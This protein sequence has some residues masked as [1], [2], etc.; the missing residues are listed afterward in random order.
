MGLNQNRFFSALMQELGEIRGQIRIRRK[1]TPK[2]NV[3][4]SV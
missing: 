2:N 4:Q 3:F 1:K